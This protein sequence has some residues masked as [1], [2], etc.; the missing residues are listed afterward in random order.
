MEWNKYDLDETKELLL[1]TTVE[2]HEK[3]KTAKLF[4]EQSKRLMEKVRELEKAA[5]VAEEETARMKEYIR[6]LE[7]E[8]ADLKK[9]GLNHD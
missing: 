1:E 4:Y 3:R 9:G 5:E 6:K 2:L 8:L 7:A